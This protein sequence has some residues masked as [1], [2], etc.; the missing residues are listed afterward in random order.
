MST[1]APRRGGT[2]RVAV[3]EEPVTFDP[4]VAPRAPARLVMD[5]VYSTLTSL[6]VNGNPGPGL[7]EHWS[8][9]ADGRSWTARLR[10]GVTFHDGAPLTAADVQF[11]LERLRRREREYTY[12][13]WVEAIAG[14]T[15]LDRLTVRLDLSRPCAALPVWLA[16]AGTAIVSRRAVE[17]GLD[18]SATPVGTGPFRWAPQQRP[19]VIRL[20]RN[21]AFHGAPAPYLDALEFHALPEPAARAA[22]LRAAEVEFADVLAAGDWDSLTTEPRIA[23]SSVLDAR[24]HWLMLNTAVAPF[25]DP[26]VRRAVAHAIDRSAIA[27]RAFAG[28]AEPILG[29]WIAPWNWAHAPDLPRFAS[30]PDAERARALLAAAGLPSG[31]RT[32]ITVGAGIPAATAQATAVAEALAAVGIAAEVE[33]LDQARYLEAVW[34]DRQYEM[35]V[36]CWASPLSDPD[37]FVGGQFRW[38]SRNNV[39]QYASAE[40][41]DLIDRALEVSGRD[42]RR[43]KYRQI[44][45]LLLRECPRIPTVFPA[46]LRAHS[47]GLRGYVPQRNGQL[48][49]LANAW[50]AE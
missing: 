17:S 21:D 4:I 19:G 5:L 24:Y 40:L 50:L 38:A 41:P 8:H 3:P 9:A 18:I 48:S 6:D 46:A 13:A 43:A 39:E 7:A 47:A 44:Q 29:G 22:A 42:V 23:T 1:D 16:F 20:E 28:H 12:W 26:A 37:D 49:S 25:T 11:S 35:S 14:V 2:L 45:E 36:M 31:F 32:R 33:T 27:A 34:R 10:P 15:V 30:G